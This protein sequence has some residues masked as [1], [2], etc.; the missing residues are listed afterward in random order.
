MWDP[1]YHGPCRLLGPDP[2]RAQEPAVD[3]FVADVGRR[4]LYGSRGA[5]F[6]DGDLNNSLAERMEKR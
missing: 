3:V 4:C 6:E 5:L 1:F 2:G